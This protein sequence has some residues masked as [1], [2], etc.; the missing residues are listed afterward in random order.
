MYLRLV[1]ELRILDLVHG[2]G[3]MICHLVKTGEGHQ[4]HVLKLVLERRILDLDL[5][6]IGHMSCHLLEPGGWHQ[7]HVSQAGARASIL[8]LDLH[9][10]GHM[11]GHLLKPGK[12]ASSSGRTVMPWCM[13]L[14]SCAASR[15]SLE[16]ARQND[17]TLDRALQSLAAIAM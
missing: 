7:V 3:H 8:D 17:K 6:G 1:Q 15:H 2:I 14:L 10:I 11:I 13:R 9:R 4:V 12:R 5:H 16:A